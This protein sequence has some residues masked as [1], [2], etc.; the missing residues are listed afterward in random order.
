M[1]FALKN[2][3]LTFHCINHKRQSKIY[4]VRIDFCSIASPRR[5]DYG[6][7]CTLRPL[8]WKINSLGKKHRIVRSKVNINYSALRH[9]PNSLHCG[10]ATN[11]FHGKLRKY[12]GEPAHLDQVR[13]ETFNFHKYVWFMFASNKV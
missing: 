7:E 3:L 9:F 10:G 11:T 8:D 6:M 1:L 4:W 12:A 2:E 13:K 5:T